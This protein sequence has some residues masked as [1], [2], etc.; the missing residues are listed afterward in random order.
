VARDRMTRSATL[1]VLLDGSP[2]RDGRGTAG[3]GRYVNGISAALRERDDVEVEL[4]DAGPPRK[5]EWLSRYVSAQPA[6]ALAALRS[7]PALVHG[8]ASDPV[9]GWPL[10]RQVVTVHDVIPWTKSPSEVGRRT[11]LYL[12][13][14]RRRLRRVA[15][16]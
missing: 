1:R 2:L 9:L 4:V 5:D 14:Q 3:I 15:A 16:V 13:A 12:R 8:L 6:L 10:H 11:A 7:R